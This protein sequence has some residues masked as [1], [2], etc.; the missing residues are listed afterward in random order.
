MSLELVV[1][2][3]DFT[4]L[5]KKRQKHFF[6]ILDRYKDRLKHYL[7]HNIYRSEQHRMTAPI[8]YH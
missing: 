7:S 4:Q 5:V 1:N 8:N 6:Y 3:I 2:S